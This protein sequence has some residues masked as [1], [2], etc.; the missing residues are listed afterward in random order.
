M[1]GTRVYLALN[2]TRT[3]GRGLGPE[4]LLELL[5]EALPE[6]IDEQGGSMYEVRVDGIGTTQAELKESIARRAEFRRRT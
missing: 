3:D 2:L 5:E 6:T 4:A 1:A